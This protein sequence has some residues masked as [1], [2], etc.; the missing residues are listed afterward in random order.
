[1]SKLNI[2]KFGRG[3]DLALLHGWGSSSKIWKTCV[4]ELSQMFR[5]W[6][7]DLPGHGDSHDIK[8]DA[9]TL[10]LGFQDKFQESSNNCYVLIQ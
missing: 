8:W 10:F 9:S 7:I 4:G 2:L 6:C 3:P 1:M 5:I